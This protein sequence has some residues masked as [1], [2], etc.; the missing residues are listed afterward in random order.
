[1]K[2]WAGRFSKDTDS[3]VNDFNSSISFDARMFKEDIE[4]SIAHAEMLGTCGIIGKAEAA[5]IIKGLECLLADIQSGSLAFDPEAEDIHMFVETVL[6]QRLGDSGKRLHTAR[7]RNDQVALD[8]RLYLRKEIKAKKKLLVEMLNVLIEKASEHTATVMP[9]Y[10]HLQR[11]QPVTLAHHLLAYAQMFKRDITRLEDCAQRMNECPLGG[12]ALAGT[13]YPIDRTL[14]AHLL[15]FDAPTQNSL[16]SVSDRD[17][18]IE[19]LSAL[20]IIM[21]HLSRFSEEIILWC[22]WEFKFI[23]LDDAY[24]TGSSI[25]PQKKNPDV[26]ELVRGKTGRVYGSL[27]TMLTV[28]KGLPLAYN[29]DMQEDKEAV[30]DALDTVKLCLETFTP[31]LSTM[32]VIKE[33]M[34]AAASRGFINATDCAD[35]LVKKGLPFRDAYKITGGLVAFCI[36]KGKTLETL[37]IEQFKE[38]STFFGNDVFKAISL[39]NCVSGRNIIGGPAAQCVKVQIEAL[40]KYIRNETDEI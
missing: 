39:E 13:T 16:D 28:M 3:R 8:I 36:E 12:G 7:S 20:S 11:A 17:F 1:M 26:A 24:A 35:Y 19:L 34:R 30:F 32:R 4:G 21:M 33:N 15:G 25:M 18:I 9:G 14:T 10:T 38:F 40:N 31:M 37:T 6:T 23:E 5:N 22:S 29:K 27:L 2:L